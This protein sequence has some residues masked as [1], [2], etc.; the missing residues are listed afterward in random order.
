M[1]LII[2]PATKEYLLTKAQKKENDR[3]HETDEATRRI[4]ES[5]LA[6]LEN[7][8]AVIQRRGI[9]HDLR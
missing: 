7:Q 5:R 6:Y 2:F 8:V 3:E 9:A 1:G 4:V